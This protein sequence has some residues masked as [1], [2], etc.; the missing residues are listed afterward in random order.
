MRKVIIALAFGMFACKNAPAPAEESK[1]KIV[2]ASVSAAV[3][4]VA[5]Q[6]VAPVAASAP[7]IPPAPVATVVAPATAPAQPIV[8]KDIKVK[9]NVIKTKSDVKPKAEPT[10][11]TDTKVHIPTVVPA[12]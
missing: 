7:A 2:D 8:A 10:K 6:A 1:N 4:P 3:I 5:P 9:E 12:K 11:P